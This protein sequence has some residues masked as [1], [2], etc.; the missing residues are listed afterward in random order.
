MG[1]RPGMLCIV[2]IQLS[3]NSSPSY[4]T[5][6]LSREGKQR[7]CDERQYLA[8]ARSR[9]WRE[10]KRENHVRKTAAG[11][12]MFPQFQDSFQ[13]PLYLYKNPSNLVL[14][15]VLAY[16]IYEDGT[17]IVFRNVCKEIFRRRGITQ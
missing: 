16:T 9:Y 12:W 10:R 7:C 2:G 6:A 3:R 4:V 14:V 5:C 13:P 11:M 15:I 1:N 8:N 17:D